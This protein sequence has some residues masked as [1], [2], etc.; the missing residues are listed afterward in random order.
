MINWR[1]VED[2]IRVAIVVLIATGVV[3]RL[4]LADFEP[5]LRRV[6]SKVICDLPVPISSLIGTGVWPR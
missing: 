5:A 1:S 4:G 6:W 2:H 3:V